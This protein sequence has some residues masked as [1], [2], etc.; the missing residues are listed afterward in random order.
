[1]KTISRRSPPFI[2]QSWSLALIVPL[3]ACT[4]LLAAPDLPI[5]KGVEAQPFT[6][7]IKRLIEAMEYSGAPFDQEARKALDV[8]L[9]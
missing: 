5:V 6:A 3:V 1:M 2:R 7:Q 8:A 9:A 4:Q